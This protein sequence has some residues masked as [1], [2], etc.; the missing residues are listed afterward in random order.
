[1]EGLLANDDVESTSNLRRKNPEAT[2]STSN[3]RRIYVEFKSNLRQNMFLGY[4]KA[5]GRV[6]GGIKSTCGNGHTHS[7]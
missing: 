5:L 4:G 3:L 6:S 1:M 2:E 7:L